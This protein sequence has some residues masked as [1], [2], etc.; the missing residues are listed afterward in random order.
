V[1]T[2][3]TD[4][5]KV[6]I[7]QETSTDV[8]CSLVVYSLIEESLMRGILDARE[9]RNIFVL[10]SGFAILPD[11]HGKAQADHTAA[12]SSSSSA[13]IDGHNNNAGSLVTVAFQTLLPGNLSG[14]LDNTGAFEDARL[15]LCYAITKIKAAVG[16]STIIPA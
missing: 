6:L 7:L 14:N 11:G 16:A 10:P 3:E 8:S 5:S 9:R 12:D 1:V 15:Q 2:D 13:P 4:S